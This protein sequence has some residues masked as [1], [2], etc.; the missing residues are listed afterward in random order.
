[1]RAEISQRKQPVQSRSR[2]TCETIVEATVQVLLTNGAACLTTT[3]VAKRAGVS[4]GTLYQYYPNKRALV[5]AVRARYFELMSRTVQAI[6][7]ESDVDDP[8]RLL[9]Q[10]LEAVIGMKR[11]NLPLSRA[12]AELPREPGQ[13][14][15]SAEIVKHYA[16]FILP[17]M[18]GEK[19]VDQI[20]RDHA[21]AT[22]AALEGLLS[23]AV[24]SEPDWL[25][26]EWFLEKIKTTARV[27]LSGT[28]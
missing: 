24:K 10:A 16:E 19:P 27:T 3:R 12:I 17:L 9:D 21:L 28:L 14:D 1:M 15:M 6:L 13:P 7:S 23:F 18:S 5:E 11:S 8:E 22:M 26:Q 2:M 4:I 20:L 25:A